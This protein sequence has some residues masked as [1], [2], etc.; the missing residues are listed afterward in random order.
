MLAKYKQK[1]FYLFLIIYGLGST[2]TSL[3][4]QDNI[5]QASMMVEIGDEIMSHTQAISEARDM[6]LAAVNLD[7]KNIRANYMAGVTTL[8]SVN[9]G[10]ARPFFQHVLEL[11]PEYSFDILY[12][13]GRALHYDYKFDEAIEYYSRYADKLAAVGATPGK[14]YA[15]AKEVDR[16][17]YECEQGK[18]LVEFPEDVEIDNA[19]PQVNSSSDDYAPVVNQNQ[20]ILIFTSRRKEGNLNPDVAEDNKP[21][22]DVYIS[23]KKDSVWTEAQNIKAP[24]NT[25]YHDS[26]V[27][28]S[29][30]GNTLFLYKDDNGGDI[31]VA[32]RDETGNWSKPESLG[33]P[34][35][36]DYAETSVSL[37]PDGETLFFASDRKGGYGGLDIW[38]THLNKKG[39]WEDPVN[40]GPEINTSY[41]EDG[42][43]IGYDG[44]TLYF[45][46]AGGE[47]MGGFDIYR[48]IYDS[49]A[50]SWGAP[51]NMGYPI[52]TP[53]HDI[54]FTP[55]E[56]GRNAYYSSA[57]EDGFGGSDIYIL[58]I[59]EVLQ[60]QEQAKAPKITVTL[61]VSIFDDSK[62]PVDASLN[63]TETNGSG[64]LFATH[65]GTG[66]Y[67]FKSYNAETKQYQLGVSA[68]GFEPQK[69]N[70]EM[71]AT[72][73]ESS[74]I[75][76]SIYLVKKIAPPPA[77]V[78]QS[79]KLRNIY[80]DFNKSAVKSEYEDKVAA[81]VA[82]L[83]AN[84]QAKLLLI[85]HS[86]LIGIEKYNTKLS[87]NRADNVKK[88]II[89]QGITASRVQTKGAGSKYPLA[90]ND[91]EKEGRELNRRVE[92]KV[93]R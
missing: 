64:M 35:N 72:G 32:E 19:G 2:T 24:I 67:S 22:E 90:S 62:T 44:K 50:G 26:N 54:Y 3:Y 61:K 79:K 7:P 60:H 77:P 92:F 38:I 87:Q 29:S 47:G 42:A 65:I 31:F 89:R 63:L 83:N 5:E 25:L 4:A 46:S 68:A 40:L 80:F 73:E 53:D 71:P 11:D 76:K 39:V 21:Y 33:K 15:T 91:Q 18:I 10:A 27:G 59:P 28:L 36:T 1:Y 69:L 14:E 48:V 82:Y 81:A 52:N 12:K 57:R 16:R 84:P 13:I 41:D 8:A 55:T 85:G 74:V 78:V 37:T 86:D 88:A 58:K 17:L 51:E 34:I 20:D 70:I 30:D 56:N 6:Y 43:F 9:K 93:I 23:F 49:L 75:E 66:V 45:S